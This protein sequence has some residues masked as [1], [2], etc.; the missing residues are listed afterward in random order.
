MAEIHPARHRD[1]LS[2]LALRA[3]ADVADFLVI[4]R[5]ICTGFICICFVY[6]GCRIYILVITPYFYISSNLK[7]P[8]HFII[9]CEK[10]KS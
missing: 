8:F 7:A 9:A 6:I 4:I 10:R 5:M 1:H 3:A 2:R